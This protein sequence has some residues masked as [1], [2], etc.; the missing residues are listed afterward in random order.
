MFAT[1]KNE[2]KVETTVAQVKKPVKSAQDRAYKAPE[3][4]A[5]GKAVEL[6]QGGGGN[7]ADNNRNLQ[8]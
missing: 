6:V 3:L 4:L 5:I 2:S 1:K 8:Y 7:S